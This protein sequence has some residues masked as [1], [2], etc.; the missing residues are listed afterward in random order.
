[1]NFPTILKCYFLKPSEQNHEIN[2][3]IITVTA[4]LTNIYIGR[5]DYSVDT[6]TDDIQVL[7]QSFKTSR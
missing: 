1:M 4:L 2:I 7:D 6:V 3:E 5:H